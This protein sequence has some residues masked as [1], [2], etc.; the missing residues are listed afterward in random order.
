[1]FSV[2]VSEIYRRC[3]ARMQKTRPGPK[4]SAKVSGPKISLFDHK[5]WPVGLLEM[6]ERECEAIIAYLSAV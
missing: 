5:P 3:S 2:S 6:L 1:L 4:V